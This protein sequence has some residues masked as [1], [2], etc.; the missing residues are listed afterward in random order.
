MHWH[1]TVYANSFIFT[2]SGICFLNL[3][4]IYIYKIQYVWINNTSHEYF[5]MS[6][7]SLTD[8]E[9]VSV[10]TKIKHI[11][12][13]LEKLHSP[14][15]LFIIL[16]EAHLTLWSSKTLQMEDS[17][18][19]YEVLAACE[20]DAS[21]FPLTMTERLIWVWETYSHVVDK[22]WAVKAVSERRLI[23]S[24]RSIQGGN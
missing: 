9:C 7:S 20:R 6:L 21:L 15:L 4:Y 5:K 17:H 23:G 11:I 12:N 3:F 13:R 8:W 2:S 22:A 1:Y 10:A 14:H 16:H 19:H 24:D 18:V